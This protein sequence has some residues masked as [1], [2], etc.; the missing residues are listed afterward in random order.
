MIGL[1]FSFLCVSFLFW[2]WVWASYGFYDADDMIELMRHGLKC[3]CDGDQ[4]L[5]DIMSDHGY[6]CWND[7]I[8]A[9]GASNLQVFL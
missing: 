3:V 8:C 1:C 5:I 7:D 4:T 6:M 9:I 2:F